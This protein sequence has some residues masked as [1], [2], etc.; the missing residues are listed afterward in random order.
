M[1]RNSVM[2]WENKVLD[3]SNRE[4]V[5]EL[6]AC[7]ACVMNSL[8]WDTLARDVV[9]GVA[10]DLAKEKGVC[11]SGL[12]PWGEFYSKSNGS[13]WNIVNRGVTLFDTF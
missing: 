6:G 10:G 8:E 9:R 4:H 7:L 12:Y 13:H 1:S 2:R 11:V 5:S 3:W